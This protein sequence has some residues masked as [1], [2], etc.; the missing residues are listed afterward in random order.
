M[1]KV[2]ERF[3]ETL[4][5]CIIRNKEISF[6]S[7]IFGYLKELCNDSRSKPIFT[8]TVSLKRKL[9]RK[10]FYPVPFNFN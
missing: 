8:Y 10:F 7:N 4:S 9:S 5:I 3:N 1:D 2:L 6:L